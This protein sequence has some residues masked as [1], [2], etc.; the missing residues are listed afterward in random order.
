[1]AGEW[2]SPDPTMLLEVFAAN[3][4][5]NA[6]TFAAGPL[7]RLMLGLRT[8]FDRNT[9]SG[10]K[11]NIA[12]HYDLG[13]KF[14]AA[15]LDP[16]MT[17]SSA[18]FSEGAND[19]EAAQ[20]QKYR[21]LAEAADI[22]SGD[23]VLEIGCGWGGFSIFAARELGCRVTALTL[24]KAQK[25]FADA[26]IAAEGLSEQITVVL[27][28][29]RDEK[30]LYDKIVSIEMFEAVGEEYWSQY[31]STLA[32]R[33]KAGGSAALQ[34][35]TVRDEFFETYR[36]GTDFLQT[37]IFPGGMLPSPGRLSALGRAAQLVEGGSRSLGEDYVRTLELWRVRFEAAWP[38][39]SAMGFDQRFRRMWLFYL[40]FCEAGF[41]R[42]VTDVRQVTFAKPAG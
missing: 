10:A 38:D 29:Y 27:R 14:Y 2:E 37:Y 36:K 35:I 40:H 19:L 24:S 16:T 34:I 42:G 23:H 30:G 1:M 11:R 25:A 21:A 26:R 4:R 3:A 20:K 9:R 5:A 39:L 31:F 18:D 15:W 17:Y 28:D 13:N 6:G 32:N 8:L 12:A 7:G 22:G 33:L 41:A